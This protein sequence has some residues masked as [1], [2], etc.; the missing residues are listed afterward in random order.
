MTHANAQIYGPPAHTPTEFSFR[1][2]R[3]GDKWKII[4]LVAYADTHTAPIWSLLEVLSIPDDE[5]AH[6]LMAAEFYALVSDMMHSL[7][8]TAERAR[9]VAN[10]GIYGRQETLF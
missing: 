9:F 7:P 2:K 6:L 1:L 4:H 8:G 10:G 3:V 5:N